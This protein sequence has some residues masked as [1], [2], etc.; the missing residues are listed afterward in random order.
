MTAAALQ[1]TDLCAWHGAA[2]A[3]FLEVIGKQVADVA[4][5]VDDQDAP[6]IALRRWPVFGGVGV[7]CDENDVVVIGTQ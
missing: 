6:R 3:L 4:V 7:L 1:V 2:Q 5:V